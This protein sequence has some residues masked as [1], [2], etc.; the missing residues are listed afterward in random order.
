MEKKCLVFMPSGDPAGYPAGHFA[1]IFDYIIVPA[2]KVA[3]FKPVRFEEHQETLKSIID[4]D[5]VLCELSS[6]NSDVLY[7]FAVRQGLHLPVTLMKDPK[8]SVDFA[9]REFNIVEYD[10]SLR[11]DMVQ[12]AIDGLSEALKNNYAN[13]GEASLLRTL[14][15]GPGT[16]PSY[17]SSFNTESFASS[18]TTEKTKEPE[19]VS[20]PYIPLPDFAGDPLTEKDIEKLKAGDSLYHT[21]YGKGVIVSIK[22]MAKEKMANI[23]FDAGIKLLVLGTSGI[24]RKIIG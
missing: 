21:T 14:N 8:T 23:Q 10:E 24:F 17:T 4:S 20:A 22:P 2:C 12:K 9:M 13:R 3:D 16:S 7:G 6:G 19:I 18:Y 11:I 5:M 1:R 15:I